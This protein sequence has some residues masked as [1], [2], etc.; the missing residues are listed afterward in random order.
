MLR[1]TMIVLDKAVVLTGGLTVEAFAH[2]AGRGHSWS[3][4]RVAA[5]KLV[6]PTSQA[7]ALFYR[8]LFE[9]GQI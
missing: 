2:G 5:R 7:A 1:K 6:A 8:R 3:A 4:L 9:V